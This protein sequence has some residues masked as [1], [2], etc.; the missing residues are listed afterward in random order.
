MEPFRLIWAGFILNEQLLYCFIP[1]SCLPLFNTNEILCLGYSRTT[2]IFPRQQREDNEIQLM[3]ALGGT[4]DS[5]GRLRQRNKNVLKL[6]R[7]GFLSQSCLFKL[8]LGLW[9]CQLGCKNQQTGTLLQLLQILSG[10]I[11]FCPFCVLLCYENGKCNLF[12]FEKSSVFI[13]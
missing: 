8:Y 1:F 2:E 9:K 13:V 10:G 11:S 7:C 4:D 12:D 3:W 5:I 6:Y